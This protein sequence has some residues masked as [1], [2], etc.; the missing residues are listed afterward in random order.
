MKDRHFEITAQTRAFCKNS[1]VVQEII[2]MI[3]KRNYTKLKRFN[4]AKE[5]FKGMKRQ[6]TEWR[7]ALAIIYCQGIII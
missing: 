3:D 5:I 2:T 6:P 4:I 7:K 1:P